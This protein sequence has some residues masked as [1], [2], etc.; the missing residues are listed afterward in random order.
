[1]GT[2]PWRIPVVLTT[3]HA[4]PVP[5]QLPQLDGALQRPHS[6][7]GPRQELLLH[8]AAALET[9]LNN[10]ADL[11]PVSLGITDESFEA[12]P[13]MDFVAPRPSLATLESLSMHELRRLVQ[14]HQLDDTGCI[15][16]VHLLK[17]L[18]P[19]CTQ[20][21][22]RGDAAPPAVSSPRAAS[23]AA[24]ADASLLDGEQPTQCAICQCDFVEGDELKRLPCSPLHAFH[25]AC[26]QQWLSKQS[27]C[28]L[29][30]NECGERRVTL[31][32]C[33]HRN[34]TGDGRR[35]CERRGI[36]DTLLTDGEKV[37]SDANSLFRPGGSRRATTVH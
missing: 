10:M 31:G 16:R 21:E 37:K 14:A 15:D 7:A 34:R 5:Q 12:I 1:M 33:R 4:T 18:G 26:I 6:A 32:G 27:S 11:E 28:P 25:T 20:Q 23:S 22:G 8:L 36:L 9:Q 19:V 24:S 2:T 29:C 17:L 13:T 35:V 3:A 30:R